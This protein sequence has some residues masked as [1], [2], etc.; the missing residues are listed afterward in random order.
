MKK[1]ASIVTA[2][3]M[4]TPA[5]A[6]AF[7]FGGQASQVLYCFNGAIYVNLGAPRGG[8]FIWTPATKTYRFGPPSHGGQW[9]LGLA[10]VPYYCIVSI[11]PV[12]VF[13]GTNIEMMGSSQ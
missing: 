8:P 1:V 6:L 10:G 4:L 3:V 13:P 2:F 12:I 9:F 11:L 7:P 5:L